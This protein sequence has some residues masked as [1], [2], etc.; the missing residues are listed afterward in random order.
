MRN[1]V[2]LFLVVI[3]ITMTTD[4]LYAQKFGI[5]AGFNLS[6]ML[7][8]DNEETY[9]DD[10]KMKPGFHI[11][12]TVEFPLTE[13]FSFET[14]LLLSTK[15]LKSSY[16]ETFAGETYKEE[17]QLNLLY[18]DIPLTA[19]A[20][21]D[22]GS[23]KIYGLFGPYLGVG[24]S[25]KSKYESSYDDETESSEEDIEWGS[26]EDESDLKRMDFGLTMGA[27]V[28]LNPIQIGLTYTLGLA[29]ISPHTDGGTKIKNR[30]L[31]ISL[32]YRFGKN[33]KPAHNKVYS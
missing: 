15:G 8:K 16:E 32:G 2:K 3:A 21:F 22:M 18:P 27:G 20:S 17:S 24:L 29:N 31:G 33:R 7:A 11:G 28:E 5:K 9:S 23:G 26:N 25:G 19:K 10:F 1:L 30:V 13:M 14:G 12:A 4:A 6:N